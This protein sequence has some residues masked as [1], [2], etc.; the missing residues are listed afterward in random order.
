MSGYSFDGTCPNCAG[1]MNC[2]SDKRPFDFA[3]GECNECGFFYQPMSGYLSL[4]ELN[5]KR[6]VASEG[7]PL[8]DL[9]FPILKELPKQEFSY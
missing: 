7:D 9:S 5:E 1:G 4:E 3:S 2:Y 8:D 6:A